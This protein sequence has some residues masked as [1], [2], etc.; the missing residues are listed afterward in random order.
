MGVFTVVKTVLASIFGPSVAAI[1]AGLAD[2]GVIV[3]ASTV[4][5]VWGAATT[6]KVCGAKFVDAARL[7]PGL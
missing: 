7:W 5:P 4:T 3:R 6:V 1:T 2:V